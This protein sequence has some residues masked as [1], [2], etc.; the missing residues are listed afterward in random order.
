MLRPRAREI[1]ICWMLLAGWGGLGGIFAEESEPPGGRAASE[2]FPLRHG[3]RSIEARESHRFSLE[4]YPG[5]W[6]RILVEEKG[7]DLRLEMTS[8]ERHWVSDGPFGG[9]GVKELA[10]VV[11]DPTEGVVEIQA[12]RITGAGRYRL[13]V[14]RRLA[15]ES[16]RLHAEAVDLYSRG[17]QLRAAGDARSLAEAAESYRDAVALFEEV[18][19]PRGA[20]LSLYRLGWTERALG[21][22]PEELAAHERAEQTATE[23]GLAYEEGL[24][25]RRLGW[26]YLEAHRYERAADAYER[27]ARALEPSAPVAVTAYVWNRLARSREL[28]GQLAGALQ[29][30]RRALALREEDGDLRR[31]GVE[32]SNLGEIQLRLG[33]PAAA[34]DHFRESLRISEQIGDRSTRAITL[35][36]MGTALR[37][38][39]RLE[40]AKRAFSESYRIHIEVA[41]EENDSRSK[42][43]NA[44]I[45]L[46]LTELRAGRLDRAGEVL[47]AALDLTQERNDQRSAA[48]TRI[49]LG[50]V[51][52]ARGDYGRAR[53]EAE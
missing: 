41:D 28:A 53:L 21:N 51:F 44:L 6:I 1:G 37:R 19:Q 20:F 2:V 17:E 39:D 27:S 42:R 32:L 11:E 13:Q 12:G 34:L 38:L 14:T 18:G 23:A 9:F 50:E 3:E 4:G 29:A 30:H 15:Q 26:I 33:R 46:G 24:A 40:E 31:Q 52:E 25:A 16:D 8:G 10:L 5:E 36:G 49:N 43:G 7:A 22:P 47:K 45:G 35:T 48:A